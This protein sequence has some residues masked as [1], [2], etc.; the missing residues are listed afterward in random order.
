MKIRQ[1]RLTP[2][3]LPL[4]RQW[5]SNQLEFSARSGWLVEL[6][7]ANGIRGYGDCAPLP[8]HGTETEEA[9]LA[10]LESILPR[11]AGVSAPDCLEVLPDAKSTPATRCALETA[12]LDLLAKYQNVPLHLWL[13]PASRPEVKANA[14][15]G[16]L[17]ATALARAYAAIDKGYAVLKLKVGV[18]DPQHELELLTRLC[19][20]LPAA[21]Q[22]RLDA[23][24]AWDI[25]TAQAFLHGV[26]G[27]PIESLEE[28]LAQPDIPA[29]AQLQEQ[30]N[31][32]LALD[33]T[34]AELDENSL[35]QIA[36]LR[37]IILKPMILGGVIPALRLGQR[38]QEL[39]IE[40]VVTTTVDSAA[41]VWMATQ[42]AAALD[43]TGRIYHGLGTTAWLQQDLGEGPD[44]RRGTITLPA[45]PGV[46]F[47]PYA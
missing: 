34:L 5:R 39:G 41:G 19:A 21:I 26:S 18:S 37:R 2:Y 10:T 3:T 31:I 14:A 22:L 27:L 11:L 1:T 25:N 32:T 30:T 8:G 47:R 23:N 9:A 4:R 35:S 13:N 44:I 7:D 38:A 43:V 46:G 24:R 20:E 15:I 40:V 16:A 12:L 33:E 29:L 17:D 28:P 42:L 6:E 45:T 36:P